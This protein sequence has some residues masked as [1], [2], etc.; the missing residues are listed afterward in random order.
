[1]E[2][3]QSSSINTPAKER[4]QAISNHSDRDLSSS[5]EFWTPVQTA[6]LVI[7]AAESSFK[8]I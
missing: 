7:K 3:A 2:L 1:M 8:W 5:P 6:G 4:K